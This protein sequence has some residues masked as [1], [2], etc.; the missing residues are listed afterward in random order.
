MKRS[1]LIPLLVLGMLSAAL[2]A[3]GEGPAEPTGRAPAPEIPTAATTSSGGGAPAPALPEEKRE[4]AKHSAPAAGTAGMTVYKDP[5]TG[6]LMP[7]PPEELRQLLTEDIRRAAS[8][9]HEGL[10]ETTAPGGGVMVDLQGRFQ[11][12]MWA[13]TGPDGLVTADCDQGDLA[14]DPSDPAQDRRK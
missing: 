2:L 7:V 12:V 10:V 11:N 9:S 8:M 4:A 6:R 14:A 1:R 3:G 13:T 5:E